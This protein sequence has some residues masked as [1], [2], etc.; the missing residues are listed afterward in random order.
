MGHPVAETVMAAKAA[1]FRNDDR[2]P[3]LIRRDSH[4]GRKRR[5]E[6]KDL[7]GGADS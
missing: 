5:R 4:S 2:L 7:L 6:L 1:K 3:R